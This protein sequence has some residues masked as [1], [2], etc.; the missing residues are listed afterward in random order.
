VKQ[1]Y[2]RP[3]T[4]SNRQPAVLAYAKVLLAD[5]K[6]KDAKPKD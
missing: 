4:P 6:I 5:K 1:E 3:I 2:P